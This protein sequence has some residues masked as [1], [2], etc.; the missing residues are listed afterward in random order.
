MRTLVAILM[1][2]STPLLAAPTPQ[3]IARAHGILK[4]FVLPSQ[5]TR[6]TPQ[7]RKTYMKEVT[8]QQL[9]ERDLLLTTED[10]K[11]EI[12][13]NSRQY[14]NRYE[15]FSS[16]KPLTLKKGELLQVINY[17]TSNDVQFDPKKNFSGVE[18]SYVE[19]LEVYVT[20]L[21]NN[22]RPVGDSFYL[23]AQDKLDRKVPGVERFEG[24]FLTRHGSVR[25]SYAGLGDILLNANDARTTTK[26]MIPAFTAAMITK[27]ERTR[28]K[29]TISNYDYVVTLF[30]LN[31]P[32]EFQAQKC[33]V[34]IN[35]TKAYHD[36]NWAHHILEENRRVIIFWGG[37]L[38]Y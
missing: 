29:W 32:K 22:L 14:Y 24:G 12:R 20:K 17:R 1:F 5:I 10:H 13:K 16:D 33:E 15:G 26:Q 30:L 38:H 19:I 34:K 31:C 37:E 8:Y 28:I 23:D 18:G 27:I 9:R 35:G 11:V 21:D 4:K 36:P 6:M 2:I 25:F 3:Q 7:Q